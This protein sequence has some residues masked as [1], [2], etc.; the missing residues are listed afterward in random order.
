MRHRQKTG[1]SLPIKTIETIRK[2]R[3]EEKTLKE[4][5]DATGLTQKQV[6]GF[7]SRYG[8]EYGIPVRQRAPSNY[9]KEFDKLWHGVIP[10]GHWMITK[11]W[12]L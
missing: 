6:C 9:R 5:Q 4:I 8:S 2:M 11:P 10:C 1:C 3:R 7:L 12:R